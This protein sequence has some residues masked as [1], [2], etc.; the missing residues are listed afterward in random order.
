MFALC[1]HHV[2]FHFLFLG[3][4]L[5]GELALLEKEEKDVDS[6]TTQFSCGAHFYEEVEDKKDSVWIVQVCGYLNRKGVISEVSVIAYGYL[7]WYMH[8]F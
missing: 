4:V 6:E 2:V 3:D 7:F 8:L 1:I 5:E